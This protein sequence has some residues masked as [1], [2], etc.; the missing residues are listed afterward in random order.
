MTAH[1]MKNK[2]STKT[3]HVYI[4]GSHNFLPACIVNKKKCTYIF[5]E[6]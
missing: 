4:L 3:E 6:R 5:N 2:V 1:K